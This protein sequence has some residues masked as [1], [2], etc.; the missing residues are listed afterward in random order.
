MGWMLAGIV[1][2]VFTGLTLYRLSWGKS[3]EFSAVSQ[4]YIAEQIANRANELLSWAAVIQSTGPM[5][6]GLGELVVSV[7]LLLALIMAGVGALRLLWISGNVLEYKLRIISYEQPALEAVDRTRLD[8]VNPRIVSAR[9][10]DT[11]IESVERLEDFREHRRASVSH[12]NT[13]DKS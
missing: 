6:S 12:N 3:L 13:Y 8:S 4:P 2:A 11:I 7:G 5:F 10:E 1:V 9:P